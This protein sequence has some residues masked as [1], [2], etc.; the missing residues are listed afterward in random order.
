[1]VNVGE[2]EEFMSERPDLTAAFILLATVTK[3][4]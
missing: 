1:M 4:L 2:R 3:S